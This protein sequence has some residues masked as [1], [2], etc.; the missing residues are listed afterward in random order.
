VDEEEDGERIGRIRGW[1]WVAA[2]RW[3]SVVGGGSAA[4]S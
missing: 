1:D 2:R 3:R 4:I